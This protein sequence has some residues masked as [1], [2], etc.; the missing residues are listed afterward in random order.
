MEEKQQNGM[1]DEAI[2]FAVRA[3]SGMVRKIDNTPFI[4]HPMEVASVAGTMTDDPEVLSAALLHDTV[5]DAGVTLEEIEARF[6][7]RV[8]ALVDAETE[9]KRRHRKP[10]DTWMERK[11]EALQKLKSSGDEG[12]HILWLA[13]KLSNLRSLRR[14]RK[15]RSKNMWQAFNQK[16]PALHAWYYRSIESLVQDLKETD[17]WQEYHALIDEIFG[18]LAK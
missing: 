14:L 3:H 10:G 16:D 11:E 2:A 8:A 12:M 5:E 4:L 1:L 15:K 13:D 18:G 7:S 9:D 6:G 17:A